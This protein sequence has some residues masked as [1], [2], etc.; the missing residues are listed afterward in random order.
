VEELRPRT[1]QPPP[2]SQL[3]Q[4]DSI[5]SSSSSF[6]AAS[7]L[8]PSDESPVSSWLSFLDTHCSQALI[9]DAVGIALLLVSG[10]SSSSN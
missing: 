1:F 5:S 2:L 8:L 3:A 10:S 4:Y 7:H 9:G 6:S